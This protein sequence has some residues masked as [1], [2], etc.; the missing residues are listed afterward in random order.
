LCRLLNRYGLTAL[1]M[2]L[3]Y[4]DHRKP[5][6]IERA[7]Y[8]VSSNVGRTIHAGRQSVIDVR[9]CLDWLQRQGYKR[10]A[11]LG[12][13]LGSCVAFITAA[14]DE[15]VR[16]AVTNHVSTYFSDVVW[17]GLSTR[18]IREGFGDVITQDELREF[19]APISPATYYP[20][21]AERDLK[22]LLIWARYDT[23]F[24]PEF[25]QEVLRAFRERGFQH[26]VYTLPC[27]HYTTGQ[28]PF[29]FMDGFAM[30][31]FAARNL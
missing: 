24:L 19:W 26:Q 10:L 13:S 16:V 20:R 14:H 29:K 30:C 2:S 23:T 17:T 28:T 3:A 31:R 11:V 22:T 4:H 7:D 5:P 25:S 9:S 12:T 6:E 15:R 1:R 8:H 21:I 18:H 27:G